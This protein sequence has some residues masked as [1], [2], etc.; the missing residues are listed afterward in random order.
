MIGG[1]SPELT[2]PGSPDL[3]YQ[4]HKNSLPP[5]IPGPGNPQGDTLFRGG[6]RGSP[7]W[8][9]QGGGGGS[10]QIQLQDGIFQQMGVF[11]KTVD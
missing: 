7:E 4:S 9:T 2:W 3:C 1:C 6:P 10:Q 8:L 5:A 11:L